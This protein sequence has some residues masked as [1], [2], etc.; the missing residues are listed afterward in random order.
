VSATT[1]PLRVGPL[2]WLVPLRAALAVVLGLAALALLVALD[3]SHGDFEI[4]LSDVVATLLGG[5]DPGQQFIVRE[6]RLP[7]TVVA[8]LV[9]AALG[10]AGALTQTFAR[11]PLASPDLLGVT[12]G[13]AVGAVGVI[14]LSGASGYGGGL[15]AGSLQQVGLPLAAFGGGLAT[16]TLLYVLSWRRGIDGQRL[17][18]VGIGIGA[19]LSAATSWLLVSARIQDA[20]SA[21]IWLN[22][23]LN[24][25]GWEQAV[26][27]LV[28]LAVLVPVALVLIRTLNAIQLGDDSAVGLGVRLQ[29]TQLLVL[30]VAVGLAAIAVS[31]VGPL[32]F[33]AFVVPQV[34]LRLTGGSRPPV[35]ASMVLGSCLVV[36]ADLV[37]RVVIPFPLPAGL[38]TAALGAPYLIW[39]LLRAN[40]KASA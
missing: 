30:L 21:Q 3:L 22:G 33:V 13:A 2:S 35:V 34:A 20:A 27:L 25:R 18:L 4:P 1:A 11:N 17:V 29:W 16:A 8:L 36:G 14:V 9:G 15:V 28:T 19:A 40:R 12:E 32:E 7:Q 31:A 26:P 23:S 6:L 5:G 37:T 10:L 24:A 38:V 39:L